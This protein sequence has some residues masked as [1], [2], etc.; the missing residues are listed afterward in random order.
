[1]MSTDDVTGTV[2]ATTKQP[3]H[4]YRPMDAATVTMV[5][6]LLRLRVVWEHKS[7]ASLSPL[8]TTGPPLPTLMTLQALTGVRL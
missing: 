8:G 3:S 1:M 2:D 6:Q 5:C 4:A 7:P